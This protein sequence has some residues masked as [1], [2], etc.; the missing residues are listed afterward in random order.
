MET[1]SDAA[2]ARYLTSASPLAGGPSADPWDGVA[3]RF[4]SESVPEQRHAATPAE[5]EARLARCNTAL[6]EMGLATFSRPKHATVGE[7]SP[8]L[9]SMSALLEQ[10][11]RELR[12]RQEAEDRIAR[13]QSDRKVS[14]Y[15]QSQLAEKLET[16]E[17]EYALLL[18]KDR[19]LETQL[20]QLQAQRASE[21]EE[22][23]RAQ[24]ALQHREN[25]FI[26]EA[27]KRERELTRLNERVASLVSSGR[28]AKVAPSLDIRG[29]LG[30]AG[31]GRPT[32]KDPQKDAEDLH[33]AVVG[34]YQD[35]LERA[36]GEMAELRA[37][38]A[39]FAADLERLASAHPL[40]ARFPPPPRRPEE[41]RA[42]GEG[43]EEEEPVAGGFAKE[44]LELPFEHARETVEE[45]VRASLARLS[46][47]LARAHQAMLAQEMIANSRSPVLAAAAAGRPSHPSVVSSPASASAGRPSDSTA[48]DASPRRPGAAPGAGPA[49]STPAPR[50]PHGVLAAA[51]PPEPAT[52]PRTCAS[53]SV[54]LPRRRCA[55]GAHGPAGE[56][57]RV[58][59]EQERL[60]QFAILRDAPFAETLE[61]G[62]PEAPGPRG[63]RG[64]AGG[65]SPGA[66]G[67]GRP[68]QH[69]RREFEEER[70][71]WRSQA[72]IFAPRAAQPAPP[73]DVRADARGRRRGGPGSP[74]SALTPT[75]IAALNS[76]AAPP[77]P[78]PV[79]PHF[80]D[81]PRPALLRADARGTA[82]APALV[83]GST[84]PLRRRSREGSPPPPPPAARLAFAA[85]PPR[86]PRDACEAP[87]PAASPSPRISGRLSATVAPGRSPSG[88][89][90]ART[91]SAPAPPPGAAQEGPFTPMF[92]PRALSVLQSPRAT[93][94]HRYSAA[95]PDS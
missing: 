4:I 21:K 16:R 79:T 73:A 27:R 74:S 29:A 63:A 51:G 3:E 93:P 42:E 30:R 61:A 92:T 44:V 34:G 87:R 60:I 91:Y 46:A 11:S 31:S 9:A 82:A 83:Q 22:L 45:G 41:A 95:P 39:A 80:P 10:R 43:E 94:P 59:A 90:L 15:T 2:F 66:A 26:H 32:W 65:G 13:L 28:E 8:I 55:D 86:E 17:R 85:P 70:S 24:A 71:R 19:D 62:G 12:F 6:A 5:I 40:L 68:A 50:T 53:R 47:R 14:Q 52:P 35:R 67:R 78:S 64:G 20:R 75:F 48:G 57:R 76:A 36:L 81:A 84:P 38:L 1:M 58:V 7:L 25:Q 69:D 56:L 77:R 33:R 49:A 72:S 23:A 18:L 89:R 54:R 88:A 37:C